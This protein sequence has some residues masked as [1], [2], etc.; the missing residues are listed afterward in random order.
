[1]AWHGSSTTRHV[2]K[3]RL[4]RLSQLRIFGAPSRWTCASCG[5]SRIAIVMSPGTSR[6][7][8]ENRSNAARLQLA[9]PSPCKI[10][11][12]QGS[13]QRPGASS[14]AA[15]RPPSLLAVR[16]VA[17]ASGAKMFGQPPRDPGTKKRLAVEDP[18]LNSKRLT[19]RRCQRIGFE[20]PNKEESPQDLFLH[21]VIVA[22]VVMRPGS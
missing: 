16:A 7:W 13:T 10:T 5:P 19:A 15:A 22:V 18:A 11:S 20:R 3:Q 21:Q 8:P 17:S 6:R 12:T 1:M 14:P 9:N 2:R 4:Y